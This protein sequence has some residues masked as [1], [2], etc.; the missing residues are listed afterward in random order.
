MAF[1]KANLDYK[2][3][4]LIINDQP[5]KFYRYHPWDNEFNH[6]V[7]IDTTKDGDWL[8]PTR[9]KLTENVYISPG[10]YSSKNRK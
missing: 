8:V 10:L 6:V 2:T 3:K 7:T 9:Q 1:T 4:S 5:F